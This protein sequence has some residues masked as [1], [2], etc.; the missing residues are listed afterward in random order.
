VAIAV[1]TSSTN[2]RQKAS[3]KY[4]YI[5]QYTH[6]INTNMRIGTD[7]QEMLQCLVFILQY[8]Q[9]AFEFFMNRS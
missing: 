7:V 1:F 6:P 8:F 4:N 5:F 2:S 9:I 3:I